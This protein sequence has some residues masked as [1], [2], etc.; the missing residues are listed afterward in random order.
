[1]NDSYSGGTDEVIKGQKAVSQLW[2]TPPQ[3]FTM[4]LGKLEQK[5]ISKLR[6]DKLF[7]TQDCTPRE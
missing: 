2:A 5:L 3:A 6:A 1:M 7:G 4:F